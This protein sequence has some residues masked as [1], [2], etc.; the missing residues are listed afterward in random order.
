MS[1]GFLL[2]E[3]TLGEMEGLNT[4]SSEMLYQMC[5][6]IRRIALQALKDGDFERVQRAER[7]FKAF[8]GELESRNI[9]FEIVRG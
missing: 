6:L 8:Y 1:K 7:D 9:E 3:Y 5:L 4:C 2:K